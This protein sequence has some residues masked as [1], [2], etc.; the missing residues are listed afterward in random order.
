MSKSM[1]SLIL[2]DDVVRAVD[3]LAYQ[4]NTSRSAMIERILAQY[5]SYMTPEERIRQVFDEIESMLIGDESPFQ[6]LVKPSSSQ[7]SLRSA[8]SYKYNP[9]VRYSVELVD[10]GAEPVLQLKVLLRSQNRT[11]IEYMNEFFRL[12]QGLEQKEGSAGKGKTAGGDAGE[13][14]ST[15]E[16]STAGDKS[17]RPEIQPPAWQIDDGRYIRRLSLP[18]E[19]VDS[20]ELGEKIAEYIRQIDDSMKDFFD[21]LDDPR[22]AVSTVRKRY[23]RYIQAAAYPL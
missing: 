21:R 11:L 1:Y 19:E 3:R 8:L 6:I 23:R 13:N 2:N 12:W 17:T 18:E 22:E 14:G 7:L 10:S 4:Y 15:E 5:V 20:N 16:I 9:T